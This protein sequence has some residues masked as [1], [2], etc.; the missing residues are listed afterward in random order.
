MPAMAVGTLKNRAAGWIKWDNAAVKDHSIPRHPGPMRFMGIG[1]GSAALIVA[2]GFVA[3]GL[4]GL[5]LAMFFLLGAIPVGIGVAVLLH[6]REK[7]PL[8]PTRFF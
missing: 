2:V 3:L 1:G 8:L 5:P 7:K 6:F 4:V